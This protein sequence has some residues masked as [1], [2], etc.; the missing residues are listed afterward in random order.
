MK[1][2]PLRKQSGN[3]MLIHQSTLTDTSP[4][5]ESFGKATVRRCLLRSSH[6]PNPKRNRPSKA[7][8]NDFSDIEYEYSAFPAI[9]NKEDITIGIRKNDT[10]IRWR[11][12][13]EFRFD[14][15]IA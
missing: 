7:I 5:I 1:N 2:S 10:S 4:L 12:T 6:D 9:E 3:V 15:I 14:I 13:K 8:L 11:L